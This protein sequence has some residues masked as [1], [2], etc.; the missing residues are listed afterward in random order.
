MYFCDRVLLMYVCVQDVPL[1]TNATEQNTTV[2]TN[3]IE[4]QEDKTITTTQTPSVRN[5]MIIFYFLFKIIIMLSVL[6]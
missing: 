1:S 6:L 4:S 5:Y 3:A 2:I